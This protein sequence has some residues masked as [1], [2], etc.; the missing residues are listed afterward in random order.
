MGSHG[1][2]QC[3]NA[4]IPSGGS[5]RVVMEPHCGPQHMSRKATSSTQHLNYMGSLRTGLWKHSDLAPEFPPPLDIYRQPTHAAFPWNCALALL[6]S[7]VCFCVGDCLLLRLCVVIVFV[8][9]STLAAPH[10]PPP[11]SLLTSL[12]PCASVPAGLV[13]R[14]LPSASSS[15][16]PSPT[17]AST[18]RWNVIC[19]DKPSV[20]PKSPL[21]TGKCSKIAMCYKV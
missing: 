21:I 12:S 15:M 16:Q 5:L 2:D 11:L 19:L 18:C 10:P 13:L 3:M 20:H 4:A 6:R 14:A 8:H 7:F 17:P 9:T 1:V